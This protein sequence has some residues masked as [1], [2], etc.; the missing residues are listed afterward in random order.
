MRP[1]I[2]VSSHAA[3]ACL[4]ACNAWIHFNYTSFTCRN[5]NVRIAS[6]LMKHALRT[7]EGNNAA[8]PANSVDSRI[9]DFLAGN[10]E[11]GELFVALYGH[12]SREPIP[13]QLRLAA[14]LAPSQPCARAGRARRCPGESPII[15]DIKKRLKKPPLLK[16]FDDFHFSNK[17]KIAQL[18]ATSPRPYRVVS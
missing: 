11:G 1:K 4:D 10:N 16:T 14:G 8:C 17:M 13:E 7:I 18:S 15:R 2:A 5:V 9:R 6:N 3:F 12:V